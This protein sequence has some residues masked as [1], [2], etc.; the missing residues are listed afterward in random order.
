MTSDHTMR[1]FGVTGPDSGNLSRA[2]GIWP[3]VPVDIIVAK[4]QPRDFYLLCSDGLTK[5][6]DDAQIAETIRAS[7]DPPEVVSKLIAQANENGGK[8][9]ISVI[10]I[11][12]DAPVV[13]R[14]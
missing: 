9:N 14:S 7:K 3:S 12:V 6:V 4:P 1:D 11:R 5:M 8:D 13:G 10:L 2:V